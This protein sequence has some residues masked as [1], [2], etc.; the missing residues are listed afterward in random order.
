MFDE[1]KT[2][3]ECVVCLQSG[4]N[5]VHTVDHSRDTGTI[6][7]ILKQGCKLTINLVT[8]GQAIGPQWA[9]INPLWCAKHTDPWVPDHGQSLQTCLTGMKGCIDSLEVKSY[10]Y[11]YFSFVL[12]TL[13]ITS[14]CIS[15][16]FLIIWSMQQAP[17]LQWPYNVT[18]GSPHTSP[19]SSFVDDW[20]TNLFIQS[21]S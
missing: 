12:V 9:G 3:P 13:R 11:K 14:G 4:G 20:L 18:V 10:A 8:I 2:I 16:F 1:L 6:H 17:L 19:A 15:F 5:C 7:Y 21:N